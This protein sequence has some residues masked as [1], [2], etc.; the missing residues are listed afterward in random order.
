MAAGGQGLA[1]QRAPLWRADRAQQAGDDRQGRGRA[2]QDLAPL[3]RHPAAAAARRTARRTSAATAATPGSTVPR[4]ESL[5]D[6]I[7]RALPYYEAEIAPALR[8]GKRVLVAAH[9]NS[10]RGDHQS[11]CRTSA[12]RRSSGWRSRPASRSSTS[13]ATTV[14]R[15]P[16]LLCE[17]S[18]RSNAAA[19]CYAALAPVHFLVGPGHDRFRRRRRRR[20][21]PRRSRR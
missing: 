4:T 16:L 18:E 8:A 2:G 3:L 15:A 21:S 12:T 1:P 10:L 6:T 9:G 7:A 5:K 13:C 17:R 19:G 11:I 20:S 14:G